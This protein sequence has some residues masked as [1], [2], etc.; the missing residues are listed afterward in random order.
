ME[1]PPHSLSEDVEQANRMNLSMDELPS[2]AGEGLMKWNES[3]ELVSV[4]VREFPPS[5]LEREDS[6]IATATWPVCAVEVRPK[7]GFGSLQNR[8]GRFR[9]NSDP[10][11][12]V[13]LPKNQEM[14]G[15]E[16]ASRLFDL[17]LSELPDP[18]S[19]RHTCV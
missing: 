18:E 7:K 19:K 5:R 4:A 17:I 9:H 1:M 6:D 15:A 12:L 8:R 10:L 11:V 3:N 14:A 2:I 13:A 16:R